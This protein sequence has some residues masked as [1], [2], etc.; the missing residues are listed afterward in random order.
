[1][2]RA[3]NI[4]PQNIESLL[5]L[6][7]VQ[8]ILKQHES[9]L[10]TIDRVLKLNKNNAQAYLFMGLNF[11]RKGDDGR[12]INSYQSAIENDAGLAEVHM[13]LGQLFAKSGNKIAIRY[14]D[15]A[16]AA[17]PANVMPLYAKA[18]YLHNND[19]LDDALELLRAII[20]K[21]HQFVDAYFRTG[22]IYLE[23]DSLEKAY[24]QFNLVVQNDPSS[25]KGFYYR[26]FASEMK[27]NFSNAKADYEQALTF[28]PGYEKA[29]EALQ[30]FNKGK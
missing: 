5:K 15:N 24:Q 16:I 26:G 22:V 12:A 19:Q 21:D 28:S 20:L 2:E 14:F 13:K 17:D 3:V 6:A 11:E 23:K 27:G 4:D 1:M 7:E 9:S 8:L 18:E 30:R 10:K 25:A 29:K